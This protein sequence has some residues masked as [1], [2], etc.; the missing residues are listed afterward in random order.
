MSDYRTGVL[1]YQSE[2]LFASHGSHS[3]WVSA[4]G[5]R[6]KSARQEINPANLHDFGW[7][8]LWGSGGHLTG[9]ESGLG[10]VLIGPFYLARV[11]AALLA[12]A[13]RADLST[14]SSFL[15]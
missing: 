9:S 6:E 15:P 10:I 2:A 4:R 11:L 13:S 3:A 14:A 5:K 7:P 12:G 1:C 8:D